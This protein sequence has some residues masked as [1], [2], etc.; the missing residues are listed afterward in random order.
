MNN[1][2][3]QTTGAQPVFHARDQVALQIITVADEIVSPGRDL[4]FTA[5]QIGQARVDVQ[6]TLATWATRFSMATG[7][8]STAV[9]R[10]PCA[11]KYKELRPGPQA[12]SKASPGASVA[13][14]RFT[15]GEGVSNSCSPLR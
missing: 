14:N 11:A 13:A 12:R 7:E 4:E 9:T 2:D 6:F 3:E 10:Q 8:P 5:L 15:S 1:R